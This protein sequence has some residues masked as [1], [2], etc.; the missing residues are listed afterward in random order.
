[1][2]IGKT[3]ILIQPVHGHSFVSFGETNLFLIPV[4]E[5]TTLACLFFSTTLN[6]LIRSDQP[7]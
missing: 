5:K 1:M 3:F 4:S 2:L 6:V 7:L